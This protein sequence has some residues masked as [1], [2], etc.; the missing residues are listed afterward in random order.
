MFETI[1]YGVQK[2]HPNKEIFLMLKKPF[3][4]FGSMGVFLSYYQWI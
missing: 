2:D 3:T 1:K 4:K